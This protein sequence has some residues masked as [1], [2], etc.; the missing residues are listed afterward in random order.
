[1]G[2]IACLITKDQREAARQHRV[3][4][5]A[6]ATSSAG[7][8]HPASSSR[9]TSS[10]RRIASDAAAE[11][12]GQARDLAGEEPLSPLASRRGTQADFQ[13]QQ[14]G[15]DVNNESHSSEAVS[16][17]ADAA[18]CSD[19]ESGQRIPHYAQV[20][21]AWVCLSGQVC[22]THS[23]IRSAQLELPAKDPRFIETINKV[24][25]GGRAPL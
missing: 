14:C 15:K 22:C 10:E 6:A 16:L 11:S 2:A 13:Q 5:A 9:N 17:A 25:A 21:R 3:A 23:P 4:G 1:M 12:Y 24:R 18:E 20:L 8:N 7:T 19:A